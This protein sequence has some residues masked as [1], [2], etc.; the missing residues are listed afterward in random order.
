M[1][2]SKKK[3]NKELIVI[4]NDEYVAADSNNL[5]DGFQKFLKLRK[6]DFQ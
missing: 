1:D 6:V 3:S 4:E 2:D 5:Q